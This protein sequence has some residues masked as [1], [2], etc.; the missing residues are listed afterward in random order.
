MLAF[1]YFVDHRLWRNRHSDLLGRGA[2]RGLWAGAAGRDL[3]AHGLSRR[4]RLRHRARRRSRRPHATIIIAWRWR[5][6]APRRLAMLAVAVAP[7]IAGFRAAG[8]DVAGLANGIDRAVAR[9]ASCAAPPRAPARGACSA[10]SMPAAIS[11]PRPR[12][13]CSACWSTINAAAR[14]LPRLARF[15]LAVPTVMQVRQQIRAR[16]KQPAEAD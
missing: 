16:A 10:S 1:A 15:A 7:A 14:R 6:S 11:A 12:P 3:G 8:D 9:R 2:G 13:C 4:R 5:G